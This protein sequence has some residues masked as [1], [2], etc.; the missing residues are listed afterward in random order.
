MLFTPFPKLG[1]KNRAVMAPMTMCACDI[2]GLPSLEL[3]NYYINRSENEIG[4]IIVESAAINDNDAKGYRNGLQFHDNKHKK[5]WERI[6]DEVHKNDS[7]IWLQLFHAGRL[8]VKEITQ[9]QPVSCSPIKTW[10]NPSYWRPKLNDSILHFQ[11]KT[12][13]EKPKELD[14]KEI[15]IIIEQFANSCKLAEEAGFDGVELHGAHGYL[16]HQFTNKET[17]QREDE[18]NSKEYKFIDLLIEECRAK[19][20]SKMILSYRLSVHMVDNS[21]LRFDESF[22]D[23]ERLIKLIDKNGID[24]FHSS[25]LKAG[26]PVFG[27]DLSLCELISQHTEKPI[28]SCGRISNLVSANKI[29]N[30][31]K[32]DLVAFGRP[33]IANPELLKN[34][35]EDKDIAFKKFNYEKHM[36]SIK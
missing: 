19:V 2:E 7:K 20:S 3:A 17:N 25:E 15:E 22:V 13:F 4:L 34:I 36:F 10:D 24:V 28:I 21:F 31:K 14:L 1:L 23:L 8:T 26:Y 35:K 29:L 5:A 9:N 30:E 12:P 33:L 18:F 11:T 16:L 27:S 32:S 6:I